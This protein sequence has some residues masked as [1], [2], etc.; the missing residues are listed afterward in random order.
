M[1]IEGVTYAELPLARDRFERRVS[2]G[3]RFA[4]APLPEAVFTRDSSAWVHGCSAVTHMSNAARQREVLLV[5]AVYT[6]HPLF[7]DTPV[8][9]SDDPSG[10]DGSD[11]LVL[12]ESCV[13]LGL[14]RR[15]SPAAVMRLA[16]RLLER[17]P[18]RELLVVELPGPCRDSSLGALMSMVDRDAF[19]AHP[20]LERDAGAYRVTARPSGLKAVATPTLSRAIGDA[21]SSPPRWIR[22]GADRPDGECRPANLLAL[23]PGRVIADED[24]QASHDALASAGIDV[25]T[26]PSGGL[27]HRGL[28]PGAMA[29]ALNRARPGVGE[30]PEHGDRVPRVGA[31]EPPGVSPREHL[32]QRGD[33]AASA[34]IRA[35]ARRR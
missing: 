23:A 7:A 34:Q 10:V 29:R 2:G 15:T 4:I 6:H 31:S 20:A 9:R 13:L 27:R 21:L 17:T 26:V 25:V 30:T 5:N 16:A 8:A 22:V 3:A 35:G 18:V 28:G 33:G 12:S 24:D 14:G 32:G 11:L 19:V 1:L